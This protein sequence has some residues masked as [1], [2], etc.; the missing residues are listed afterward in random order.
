MT[1]QIII[2][3]ATLFGASENDRAEY[4]QLMRSAADSGQEEQFYLIELENGTVGSIRAEMLNNKYPENM[5]HISR[6]LNDMVPD[7]IVDLLGSHRDSSSGL[8]SG[9]RRHKPFTIIK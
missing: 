3:I 1:L 4:E 6:A 7:L 5:P 9:K 8:P 2:Y